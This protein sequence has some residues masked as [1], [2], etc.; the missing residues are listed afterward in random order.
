VGIWHRFLLGVPIERLVLERRWRRYNLDFSSAAGGRGSMVNYQIRNAIRCDQPSLERLIARSARA[1]GGGDYRPEQIDAALR[2]VF[3]VDSQLIDDG[4][5]FVAD[6]DGKILGCGGWSR[7]R[8][9]FGG[10]NHAARDAGELD[11]KVDAARIRAFFV[12]P[13]FARRGIGR[14]LLGRCEAEARAYGFKRFELMGTL[15]G[16][17]L[18]Q[19]CGYELGAMLRYPLAAD[20]MIEFAAMRK[21][22]E[23]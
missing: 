4:T 21:G 6:F 1:L 14:A 19:A 10:D 5:Y 8:T 3:G 22:P 17:P 15:T 16:I 23:S 11:P 13:D 7:R 18:Y 20:L 2:G 9:L 12:D